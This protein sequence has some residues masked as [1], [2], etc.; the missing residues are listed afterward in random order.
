MRKMIKVGTVKGKTAKE[1]SK[2][3][4]CGSG[5]LIYRPRNDCNTILDVYTENV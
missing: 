3:L 4:D 5:I 2:V 1:I